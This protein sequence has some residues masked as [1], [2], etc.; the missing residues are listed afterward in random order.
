MFRKVLQ[1]ALA[2][3]NSLNE[4]AEH[5]EHGETSVFN[6]LDLELSERVG[7]VSKAQG[8]ESLTG[9]E[10]VET[11]TSRATIYTVS[12]NETH[13]DDL[14]E[15]GSSDGLGVDESGV[16]EVVETI[17]TKD[18]GTSLEPNAGLAKVDG[19]VALEELG[20]NASESTK[21]GPAS[22][23]DFELSVASKSFGISR[24]TSGIPAVVTGVLTLEVRYIGSEGAKELGAVSTVELGTSSDVALQ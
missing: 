18:A 8:V 1:G 2:S 3:Y 14:G 24:H 6:F 5:G 23:D 4:E 17:I 16:T 13:E 20:G 11:L 10:G 22:V 9:V 19:T 15:E 7:V 21:H 12:L